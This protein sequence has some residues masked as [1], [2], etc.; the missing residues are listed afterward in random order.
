[1]RVFSSFLSIIVILIYFV[2]VYSNTI[3]ETKYLEIQLDEAGN[4]TSLLDTKTNSEYL[5]KDQPAPLMSI[6][7]AGNLEKPGFFSLLSGK[8]AT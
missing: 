1:M 2:P 7:I 6:R 3:F 5:F 8:V 4:I